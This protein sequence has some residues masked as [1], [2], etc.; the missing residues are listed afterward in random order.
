MKKSLVFFIKCHLYVKATL[1]AV[2][3]E[4][5]TPHEDTF[6]FSTKQSTKYTPHEDTFMFQYKAHCFSQHKQLL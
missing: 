5:H 4:G 1:K 2:V 3:V 6:M